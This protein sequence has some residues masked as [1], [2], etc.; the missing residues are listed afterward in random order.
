MES[1]FQDLRFAL[2][3]LSKTPGFTIAAVLTLALGIGAMTAMFTVVNA[4]FL[5]PLPFHASDRLVWATE[6]YP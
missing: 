6:F 2:R 5:C 3:A 1:T 4:A